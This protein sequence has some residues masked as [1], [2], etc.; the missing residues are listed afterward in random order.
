MPGTD[1]YYAEDEE[2]QQQQQ[3]DLQ[4]LQQLQY[5]TGGM[6]SSRAGWSP[7][8]TLPHTT[9]GGRQLSAIPGYMAEEDPLQQGERVGRCAGGK[10]TQRT[11]L[12]SAARCDRMQWLAVQVMQL[13]EQQTC[14]C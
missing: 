14:S 9:G 12:S 11:R 6:V 7:Q 13:I 5:M 1:E 2:E 10:H 4:Q 3:Q 8:S